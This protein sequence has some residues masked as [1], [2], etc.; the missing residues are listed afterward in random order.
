MGGNGED[1]N[2]VNGVI[3]VAVKGEGNVRF[4]L[5][6][7]EYGGCIVSEDGFRDFVRSTPGLDIRFFLLFRASAPANLRLCIS[8]ALSL[9]FSSP[10]SPRV[11]KFGFPTSHF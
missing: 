10:P 7:W 2:E 6:E 5:F 9:A 8:L 1:E 3:A 11:P 4:R